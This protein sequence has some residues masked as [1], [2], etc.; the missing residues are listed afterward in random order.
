M[1]N[2]INSETKNKVIIGQF[3][4][5]DNTP[6]ASRNAVISDIEILHFL[7]KISSDIKDK[8][9]GYA[10]W[11]YRDYRGNLLYNSNFSLGCDG[12]FCKKIKT[13]K[14]KSNNIIK[15]EKDSSIEQLIPPERNHFGYSG[16]FVE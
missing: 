10:L 15:L 1:A 8:T 4:F 3:L 16:G 5:V 9:S 11:T 13:I 7:E 12:W 14:N 6:S 2:K